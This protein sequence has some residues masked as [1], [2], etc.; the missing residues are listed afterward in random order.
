MRKAKYALIRFYSEF[1]TY[2]RAAVKFV[3]AFAFLSGICALPGEAGVFELLTIRLMVSALCAIL[4]PNG[5]LLAAAVF[6]E[7]KLWGISL[8]SG[9]AGAVVFLVLL[10]FYFSFLSGQSY[11]VAVTVLLLGLKLPL[12]VPVVCGLLVGPGAAAGMI[13]GTA[14]YYGTVGLGLWKPESEVLGTELADEFLSLITSFWK[15]RE[16][17]LMLVILLAVFLVVYLIRRL[18][19][20]YSWGLAVFSGTVSYGVLRGMEFLFFKGSL[21]PVYFVLD[22]LLGAAAGLTVQFFAF[23]LDY[24]KV[25][26]LQF[27]DD[28]YYYYVKAIPKMEAVMRGKGDEE[29]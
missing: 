14:A 1:D 27:E 7:A 29:S 25:Q 5:L 13:F 23:D 28:D 2:L 15:T 6:A 18:P 3:L 20:R 19:V 24:E 26:E 4:P 9:L 16:A 17:V 21:S 10:L 8:V 22:L 11:I 12:A